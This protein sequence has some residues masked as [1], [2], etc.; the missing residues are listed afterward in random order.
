VAALEAIGVA[1]PG[2]VDPAVLAPLIGLGSRS[3]TPSKEIQAI[4]AADFLMNN[5]PSGA[6]WIRFNKPAGAPPEGGRARE[7]RRRRRA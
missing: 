7:G 6:G 1:I 2:D 4:R 3:G 5:D